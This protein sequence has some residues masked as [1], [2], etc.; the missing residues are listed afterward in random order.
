MRKTHPH[1]DIDTKY[2]NK[3]YNLFSASTR[4][5]IV[6]DLCCREFRIGTG[7]VRLM[8]EKAYL[9]NLDSGLDPEIHSDLWDHLDLVLTQELKRLGIIKQD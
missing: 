7:Q 8:E 6:V 4:Q 2:C 1:L 5:P 9:V 3:E